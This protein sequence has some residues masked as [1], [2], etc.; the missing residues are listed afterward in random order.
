[1][2][3]FCDPVTLDGE[4]GHIYVNEKDLL[5]FLCKL[6]QGLSDDFLEIIFNYSS[7]Q[8]VSMAVNN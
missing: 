1:M 8:V 7:R 2:L 3:T 6:G 5:T 4:R